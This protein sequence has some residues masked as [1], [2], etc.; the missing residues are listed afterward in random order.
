MLPKQMPTTNLADEINNNML[1]TNDRVKQ[2]Y[3]ATM[4]SLHGGIYVIRWSHH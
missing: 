1:L 2:S 4:S 3:T